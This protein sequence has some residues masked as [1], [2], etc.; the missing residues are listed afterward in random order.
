[1][2]QISPGQS[3]ENLGC[4]PMTL[5]D[6]RVPARQQVANGLPAGSL[7]DAINQLRNLAHDSLLPVCPAPT[8]AVRPPGNTGQPPPPTSGAPHLPTVTN[9]P[10]PPPKP[11]TDC[12]AAA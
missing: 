1:L 3:T 9:L 2:L 12:R 5:Q 4:K 8:P 11:G 10:S 7:D 6:L